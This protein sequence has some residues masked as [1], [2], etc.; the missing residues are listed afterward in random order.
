MKRSF[1]VE[2]SFL[3]K[4]L[5]DLWVHFRQRV[6]L[7]VETAAGYP[8]TVVVLRGLGPLSG[9]YCR[10]LPELFLPRNVLLQVEIHLLLLHPKKETMT[11]KKQRI[12]LPLLMTDKRKSV[13]MV[14]K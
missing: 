7:L 14:M 12:L 13:S 3:T 10:Y 9:S 8:V 11:A 4:F 6:I 1:I 5:H 2:Y